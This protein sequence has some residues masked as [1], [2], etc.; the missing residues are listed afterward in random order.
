MPQDRKVIPMPAHGESASAADRVR[1]LQAEAR[2]LVNEHVSEFLS[3]L[4]NMERVSK[5]IAVGG[6]LYPPGVVEIARRMADEMETKAQA[7]EAIM[8]RGS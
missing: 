6:P 4:K 5:E 8:S 1:R 2:G 3:A 7:V